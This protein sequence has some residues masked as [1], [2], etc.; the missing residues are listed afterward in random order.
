MVD[1][2]DQYGQLTRD[3]L[4]AELARTSEECAA[5]RRQLTATRME[6]NGARRE[7]EVLAGSRDVAWRIRRL[8]QDIST[9]LS[10]ELSEARDAIARVRE[11]LDA[12][13]A[14]G[15]GATTPTLRN[16]CHLLDGRAVSE[17][18]RGGADE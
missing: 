1:P 10:R 3:E 14:D 9:S 6:L 13:I 4:L 7:A 12:L 11:R 16:L 18:T 5:V 17:Q 2:R 15:F 8:Q